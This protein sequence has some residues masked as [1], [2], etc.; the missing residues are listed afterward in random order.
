MSVRYEKRVQDLEGAV[1]SLRLRL[2]TLEQ[3]SD[4]KGAELAELKGRFNCCLGQHAEDCANYTGPS[5][6]ELDNLQDENDLLT[7]M[8][9]Q[10]ENCPEVCSKVEKLKA[11]IADLKNDLFVTCPACGEK[12]HAHQMTDFENR[13][14]K[15]LREALEWY[16]DAPVE[17]A[18]DSWQHDTADDRA[19]AAGRIGTKLCKSCK[20]CGFRPVSMICPKCGVDQSLD[21]CEVCKGKRGGVKGNEN[22][23]WVGD[24]HVVMCDD[25]HAEHMSRMKKA[26][27]KIDRMYNQ[28]ARREPPP[29]H[30]KPGAE[31]AYWHYCEDGSAWWDNCTCKEWGAADCPWC[32][33]NLVVC[34]WC[35]DGEA[36]AVER[37]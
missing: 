14:I 27:S 19:I 1:K 15:R 24:R 21:N 8:V 32:K 4:E 7:A 6:A 33:E 5:R 34:P 11:E 13:Y 22:R 30:L 3:I 2:R 26:S 31:T 29:H 12:Y 10:S 17:K 18:L 36:D 25:C 35:K 20:S 37:L 23:I 28:C 16:A 9:K